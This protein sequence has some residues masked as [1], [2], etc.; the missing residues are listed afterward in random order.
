MAVS[1][2][3]LGIVL[4][5]SQSAI[6][7]GLNLGVFSVSRLW[8]ETATEAGDSRARQVLDL[9]R[10][11]NFTLVTILL[12]NVGV[13]VL[14]TLLADS[15]L[16]GVAAFLFS[17]VAITLLGEIVPQAY[18][19]RHALRMTAWLAPMLSAYQ[20]LLWPVARPLGRLLDLWVGQ[21]G[22]QLFREAELGD[23][24]RYH[25]REASS[26]VSELEATGAI[27]FLA[28]DDLQVG[29]EGEPISPASILSL[30]FEGTRPVFP[31]FEA[32]VADPFLKRLEASSEKWVVITDRTDKPRLVLDADAFLRE[33][34]F[35]R[36][37]CSPATYC[38]RPLVVW[39]QRQPLGRVLGQF[40][41]NPELPGDDVV[42][43]DLILVWTP[44]DRRIITGADILGRLLRGI[45]RVKPAV[46][47]SQSAPAQAS[48][49]HRQDRRRLTE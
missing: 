2:T 42:D 30:P 29:L 19:S 1:L 23:I 47:E 26:D 40:T 6:F 21:E 22:I 41:V 3:W 8:L 45:V 38:H 37:A 49:P 44:P 24:L 5:I 48:E 36:V 7:S 17:T 15:V 9:R 46:D 18:L 20:V 31:T 25:A 10:D 28:L 34:L 13:N 39:D 27:N 4:C 43:E 16:A 12:G 11:A 14:L 35:S 33:V 32:S